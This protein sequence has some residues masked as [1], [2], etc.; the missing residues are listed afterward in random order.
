MSLKDL[1][2]SLEDLLIDERYILKTAT[3]PD[4]IIITLEGPE[5]QIYD[6][7]RLEKSRIYFG[8]IPVNNN[9]F[10][11]LCSWFLDF[12]Q[13]K[14]QDIPKGQIFDLAET[15]LN[16]ILRNAPV[17]NCLQNGYE[18]TQEYIDL[19]ELDYVEK[20]QIPELKERIQK[21]VKPLTPGIDICIKNM[22]LFNFMQE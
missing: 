20:Y 1:I 7:E 9:S 17:P 2:P 15:A 11:G 4:S 16:R 13:K 19:P 21:A 3:K 18:L 12:L 10:A 14:E 22:Q 8:D 5:K 6:I